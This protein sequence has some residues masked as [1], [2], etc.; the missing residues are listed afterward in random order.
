MFLLILPGSLF[1]ILPPSCTFLGQNGPY[2]SHNSFNFVRT[3]IV[4]SRLNA[5]STSFLN[6]ADGLTYSLSIN[7]VALT[8][9]VII[10]VCS[11][12]LFP[13]RSLPLQDSAF[14]EGP[15][16]RLLIV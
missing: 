9:S 6:L 10:C 15:S 1:A 11:P 13:L 5:C 12:T 4:S 8:N 14:N 16:G 2:L 3:A 7:K